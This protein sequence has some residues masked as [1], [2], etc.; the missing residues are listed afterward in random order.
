MRDFSF[1][2]PRCFGEAP[3]A[4]MTLWPHK[5]CR[6]RYDFKMACG[7]LFHAADERVLDARAELLGL[8]LHVHHQLRPH[9]AIREAGEVFDLRGRGELAAGHVAGEDQGLQIGASGVNRRCVAGAAGADDDDVFHGGF[10]VGRKGSRKMERRAG[11]ARNAFFNRGIGVC[12][13]LVYSL[14]TT[15]PDPT[16]DAKASRRMLATLFF[17]TAMPMGMWGVPLANVFAAHG[18]GHLVP[19][20]LATTS[21]AAFISPLFVGALAD[22][23]HS[24][25][26]CCAG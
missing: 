22:Q 13:R 21:I 1:G 26:C 3:V 18:R 7:G 15:M 10:G 8:R 2:R 5:R 17:C 4:T 23:K 14:L 20:V 25:C 19:W 11:G 16:T 9:D 24:P 12:P 6:L